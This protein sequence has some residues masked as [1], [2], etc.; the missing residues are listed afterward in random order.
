MADKLTVTK[1]QADE[2][3]QRIE[4]LQKNED[5][6]FRKLIIDLYPVLNAAITEKKLTRQEVYEQIL[7]DDMKSKITPKTFMSYYHIAKKEWEERKRKEARAEAQAKRNAV[8]NE[9]STTNLNDP[10]PDQNSENQQNETSPQTDDSTKK[11]GSD[12]VEKSK[13]A[14]D[15]NDKINVFNKEEV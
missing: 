11:T 1:Q 3:K 6:S 7:D 12:Y 8:N 9:N 10:A 13:T 14:K 15:T 5:K 4:N 2:L